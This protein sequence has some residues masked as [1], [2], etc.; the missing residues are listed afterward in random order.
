[1]ALRNSLSPVASNI[2]VELFKEIA[3]GTADHKPAKLLR[4]VDDTFVVG[5]YGPANL[6]QFLI[7]LNNL[8]RPTIKFTVEV[9]AN[10]P[11]DTLPF[12]DILS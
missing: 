2:F 1:M 6:Q 8:S 3:L 10:D 7:H 9:Q 5:S 4:Y 12:L 11:N